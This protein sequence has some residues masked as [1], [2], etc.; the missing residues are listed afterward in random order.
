MTTYVINSFSEQTL[1]WA[2]GTGDSGGQ[3]DWDPG[4][5]ACRKEAAA[6]VQTIAGTAQEVRASFV[7][8]VF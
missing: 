4:P 2:K 1:Q 8:L 3:E 5:G 7:R 6:S